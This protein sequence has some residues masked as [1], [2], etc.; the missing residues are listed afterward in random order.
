M[1]VCVGCC[2]FPMGRKAY[3]QRFSLVE[4]Q[5]TFCKPPRL[6]TLARWHQEAP[7]GFE[8][9]LKAWQLI[10]HEPSSSMV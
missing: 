10:T 4:V 6:E 5:Q 1:G 2:G 7:E 9:I 8:F 3:F